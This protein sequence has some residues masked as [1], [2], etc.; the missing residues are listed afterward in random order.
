MNVATFVGH[1]NCR[2]E[3]MGKDFKRKATA[4]EIARMRR[5]VAE[6]MEAAG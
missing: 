5:L 3:V 1:G 2:D 4:E 6:G